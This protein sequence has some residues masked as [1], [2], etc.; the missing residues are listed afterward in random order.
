MCR[1]LCHVLAP[2]ITVRD[3]G[4]ASR[5]EIQGDRSNE[6]HAIGQIV[7]QAVP[8]YVC[9]GEGLEYHQRSLARHMQIN[10]SVR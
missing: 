10:L 5:E 2:P 7:P 8:P 4:D 6:Q 9:R 3:I 1:D